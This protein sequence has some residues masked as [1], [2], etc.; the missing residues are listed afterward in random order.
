MIHRLG[1]FKP[2][3]LSAASLSGKSGEIL[4]EKGTYNF[5]FEVEA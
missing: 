1:S 4:P 2:L 5:I 3:Q